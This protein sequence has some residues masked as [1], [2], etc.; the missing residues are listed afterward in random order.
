MKIRNKDKLLPRINE[1]ILFPRL[2][3]VA[4]SKIKGWSLKGV[5]IDIHFEIEEN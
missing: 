1:G 2:R 5:F 3:R 4:D